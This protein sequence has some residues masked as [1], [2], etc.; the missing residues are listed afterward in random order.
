MIAGGFIMDKKL[1][2]DKERHLDAHGLDRR[3][4]HFPL[5]TIIV[6]HHNYSDLV[7][8]CLLSVLDQ[9][10]PNWECVI[11]DDHSSKH[12]RNR[13]IEI[14]NRL[15]I[16]RARLIKQTKQCGQVAT[17]FAGLAESSGEFVSPLD[18]DD[19][20]HQT[21]LEEMMRAHLNDSLF[22][23]IVSC[24][25]KL[26]RIGT[27]L[28]SGTYKGVLRWKRGI[29]IE[30]PVRINVDASD[31]DTL[32]YFANSERGWLWTATSSLMVRRSAARLLSSQ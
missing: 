9:T 28:I 25:Q 17:F 30:Y 23:P 22:C 8:E 3:K 19:R 18:P 11:I 14:I 24:E 26:L 4:W 21:Y 29:K 5:C 10:Y 6:P 32:L 31:D 27:G 20:L 7:E 15:S 16:P 2:L 12:H 1:G 13:L